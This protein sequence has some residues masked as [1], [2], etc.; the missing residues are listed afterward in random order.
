[1]IGYKKDHHQTSLLHQSR[2]KIQMNDFTAKMSTIVVGIA[3]LSYLITNFL[4]R[5]C[6]FSRLNVVTQS[7]GAFLQ[8]NM[9]QVIHRPG[10]GAPCL[11]VK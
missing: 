3:P 1:M 2:S 10:L 7:S 5:S 11:Q 6:G 4:V 8:I 9:H